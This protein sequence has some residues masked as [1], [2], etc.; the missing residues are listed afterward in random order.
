MRGPTIYVSSGCHRRV[1]GGLA[2]RWLPEIHDVDDVGRKKFRASPAGGF[3]VPVDGTFVTV[4]CTAPGG[5]D[6]K[7]VR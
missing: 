3:G 6:A 5:N 4:D 2:T 1:G 7:R